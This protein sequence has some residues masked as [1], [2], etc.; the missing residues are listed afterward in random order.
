MRVGKLSPELLQEL[1]LSHISVE[2]DD[3]LVH[4][5]LGEDCAVIDFG[6]EVC[7]ISS[8][9]ITGAVAGIGDWLSMSPAMT[10]LPAVEAR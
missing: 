10:W 3:V 1:V 5:G 8:D 9:P 6:D 2:R 7:I 4:A